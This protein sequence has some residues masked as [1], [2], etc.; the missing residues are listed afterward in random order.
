MKNN[1]VK[2]FIPRSGNVSDTN[3][4]PVDSGSEKSK[5]TIVKNGIEIDSRRWPRFWKGIG[6][7]VLGLVIG[8]GFFVLAY[9]LIPQHLH[10]GYVAL[11]ILSLLVAAGILKAFDYGTGETPTL[12]SGPITIALFVIFVLSLYYGSEHQTEQICSEAPLE[13]LTI[14]TTKDFPMTSRCYHRGEQAKIIVLDNPVR[15]YLGEELSVGEHI[16]NIDGD[17]K[18]CFYIEKSAPAKVEVY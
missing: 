9:W 10:V 3:E 13:T 12:M 5:Y 11:S 16:I 2:K 4:T 18:L 14:A 17:G 7:A 15:M 6:W 1:D 8:I